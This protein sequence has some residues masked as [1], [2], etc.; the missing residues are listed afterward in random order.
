MI[1]LLKTEVAHRVTVL[2]AAIERL[3]DGVRRN[4]VALITSSC[5][6]CVSV[7]TWVR[8]TAAVSVPPHALA[9]VERS[10]PEAPRVHDHVSDDEGDAVKDDISVVVPDPSDRQDSE[11]SESDASSETEQDELEVCVILEFGVVSR[12]TRFS[13]HRYRVVWNP[14]RP[15]RS[16]TSFATHRCTNAQTS[17]H[18]SSSSVGSCAICW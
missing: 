18:S 11:P 10:V 9:P 1:D 5:V 17:L 15:T 13:S 7:D 14:S 12:I 2:K 4:D 8:E 3:E 16:S 6:A